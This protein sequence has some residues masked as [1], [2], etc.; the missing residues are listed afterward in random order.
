MLVHR[1]ATLLCGLP[2]KP[3]HLNYN[4]TSTNCKYIL[5]KNCIRSYKY[6]YY[7]VVTRQNIFIFILLSLACPA[8]FQSCKVGA[9]GSLPI[10]YLGFTGAFTNPKSHC[11][12]VVNPLESKAK[13]SEY[14]AISAVLSPK[15]VLGKQTP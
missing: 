4:T 14:N 5:R 12:A 8:K 7:K 2:V 9:S 15:G 6:L 3:L 11:K 13:D 10:L 1:S